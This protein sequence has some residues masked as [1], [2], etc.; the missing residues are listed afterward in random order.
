MLADEADCLRLVGVV[1]DGRCDA[2]EAYD[3]AVVDEFHESFAAWRWK[4]HALALI[5]VVAVSG[6]W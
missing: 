4:K 3:V 1:V 5:M 6:S 2:F